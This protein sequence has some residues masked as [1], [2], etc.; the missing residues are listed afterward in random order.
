MDLRDLPT[1][2]RWFKKE[3]E[4]T[5]RRVQCGDVQIELAAAN[6]RSDWYSD[7]YVNRSLPI[8]GM[9]MRALPDVKSFKV[10]YDPKWDYHHVEFE[11]EGITYDV[12]WYK[13]CAVKR[14][15]DNHEIALGQDFE[16]FYF[17]SQGKHK[18]S[19]HWVKTTLDC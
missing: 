17:F 14:K 9:V 16:V 11:S 4:D 15:N 13:I 7:P 18:T 8:V 5:V 2:K 1:F 3:D 6:W 12:R 10:L 19:P